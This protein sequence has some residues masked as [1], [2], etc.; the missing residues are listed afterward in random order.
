MLVVHVHVRVKPEFAKRFREATVEN[1]R[2]S[3]TE[4]GIARFDVLEH[5]SDP[6]RFVLTEVYR[7]AGA[8]AA[9]KA[10]AHYQVWRDSVAEMMAEPRTSVQFTNVFPEEEEAW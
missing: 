9:H 1:A 10:T 8:A 6:T 4:T 2:Q 5:A 3:L 7:T